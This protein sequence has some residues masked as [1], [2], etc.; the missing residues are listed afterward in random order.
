[1]ADPRGLPAPGI[2][3]RHETHARGDAF[4]SPITKSPTRRPALLAPLALV[5]TKA[6]P[7]WGGESRPCSAVLLGIGLFTRS[8]NEPPASGWCGPTRNPALRR[9]GNLSTKI[10]GEF[11]ELFPRRRSS[12]G[13]DPRGRS[14]D[15]DVPVTEPLER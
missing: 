14:P 7:M 15:Q 12:R 2:T 13:H 10:L 8:S 5:H 6:F 3:L 1:M 9:G 4:G 11:R